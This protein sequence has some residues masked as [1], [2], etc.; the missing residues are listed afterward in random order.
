MKPVRDYK[1][2]LNEFLVARS[3]SPL[4]NS[5]GVKPVSFLK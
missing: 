5:L 2:E 4:R 3:Y 1:S